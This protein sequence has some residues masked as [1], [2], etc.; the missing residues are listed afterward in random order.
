MKRMTFGGR[1]VLSA[2]FAGALIVVDA[3]E[4]LAEKLTK[5]NRELVCMINNKV[6]PN[7]QEPTEVGGKTYY[8][9]CPMCA[10]KLRTDVSARTGRDPVSGKEVDKA[11]A[12]IGANP[13]GDVRYFENEANLEEYSKRDGSVD[14]KGKG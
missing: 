9:C 7:R 3:S 14:P 2:A 4:S 1:L 13:S 10:E 8:G 6:F 5:V 12:V 11:T